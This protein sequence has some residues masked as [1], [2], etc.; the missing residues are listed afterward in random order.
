VVRWHVILAFIISGAI[1]NV[2]P[3]RKILPIDPVRKLV[4][5]PPGSAI[6]TNTGSV[7]LAESL[8]NPELS[9]LQGATERPSHVF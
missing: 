5:S 4:D 1:G 2:K 7:F 9:D 6:I 3:F 8:W